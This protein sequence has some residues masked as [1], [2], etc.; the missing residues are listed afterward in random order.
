MKIKIIAMLAMVLALMGC[1][2]GKLVAEKQEE[3]VKYRMVLVE[4]NMGGL[5]TSDYEIWRDTKTNKEI[6]VVRIGTG[7]ACTGLN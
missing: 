3:Q 1:G 4:K 7:T 5:S 2:S 6:F